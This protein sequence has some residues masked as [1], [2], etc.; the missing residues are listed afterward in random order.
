MERARRHDPLTA[1]ALARLGFALLLSLALHAALLMR[2]EHGPRQPETRAVV[3]ARLVSAEPELSKQATVSPPVIPR[4]AV[5]ASSPPVPTLA[6]VAVETAEAAAA[7]SDIQNPGVQALAS[8]HLPVDL[9]YYAAAELD[10]YPIPTQAIALEL[11]AIPGGW[12]RILTSIG[13]TGHVD[14]AVV[15]DAAPAGVFDASALTAVRR[16]RFSPARR[17]GRDVRSRVLIELRVPDDAI[18]EAR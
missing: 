15:F 4:S 2:V 18:A 11:G 14:E 6:P 9:N 7:D 12:I 5:V 10:V 3:H 17:D 13:E 16:T 8:T 1:A